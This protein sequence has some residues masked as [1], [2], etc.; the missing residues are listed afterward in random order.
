MSAVFALLAFAVTAL[1]EVLKGS[2]LKAAVPRM[3]I[4]AFVMAALGWLAGLVA[5]SAVSE[6]VETRMPP[7]AEESEK[8]DENEVTETEDE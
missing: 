7:L 3:I 6:A 1:L 5:E 4:A 2:A 8:P